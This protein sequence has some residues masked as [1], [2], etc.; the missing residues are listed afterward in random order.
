MASSFLCY[1]VSAIKSGYNVRMHRFADNTDTFDGLTTEEAMS[2]IHRLAFL[3]TSPPF[4]HVRYVAEFTLAE[5]PIDVHTKAED[6]RNL[7][8]E[9]G[10][11][12]LKRVREFEIVVREDGSVRYSYIPLY[13]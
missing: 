3:F 11:E 1:S 9:R 12:F 4:S 10:G 13:P 5:P 7:L 6:L 2:R 8:S